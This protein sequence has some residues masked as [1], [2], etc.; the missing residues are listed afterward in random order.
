MLKIHLKDPSLAQEANEKLA[1]LGYDYKTQGV[2]FDTPETVKWQFLD[3]YNTDAYLKDKNGQYQKD[4][5]TGGEDRDVTAEECMK[6]W[7]IKYDG[8]GKVDICYGRCPQDEMQLL[9]NFIANNTEIIEKVREA[10]ELLERFEGEVDKETVDAVSALDYV[11]E[12]PALL[13]E[14]E[15]TDRSVQGGILKAKSWGVDPFY[16]V[17][18]NVEN[19]VFMKDRQ[20]VEPVYDSLYR[21][22]DGLAVMLVPQL[23][24]DHKAGTIAM[25]T[26]EYAWNYLGL[27][28]DAYYFIHMV[29][30]NCFK[31]QH[32]KSVIHNMADSFI[33]TYNAEELK[34]RMLTVA[35][36]LNKTY[37]EYRTVKYDPNPH[38][39]QRFSY[40]D[41]HE[42]STLCLLNALYVACD[43]L[44]SN[45]AASAVEEITTPVE[46]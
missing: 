1:A 36:Y 25:N 10:K 13:P 16:I 45:I 41:Q 26:F 34:E 44:D 37:P 42:N 7:N 8:I 29:W 17:F 39:W 5:I 35:N 33:D 43:K 3:Y 21:C 24:L 9:I 15:R 31:V 23:P 18:G 40:G 46:A 19:P 32:S 27:R 30:K 38:R 6:F 20:H 28:E 4:Q 2:I 11:P 12:P 22:D 14:E